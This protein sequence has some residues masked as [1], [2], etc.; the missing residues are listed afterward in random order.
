MIKFETFEK[1]EIVILDE[2]Y[3]NSSKVKVVGQSE[4]NKMFTQVTDLNEKEKWEVMTNRLTKI[5]NT[6]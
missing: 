6:K 5:K 4:P 1:D 3:R 2:K